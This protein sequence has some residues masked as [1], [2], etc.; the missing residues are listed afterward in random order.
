M[1]KDKTHPQQ[2]TPTSTQKSSD[3]K[4]SS[5]SAEPLKLIKTA[6]NAG[7]TRTS[8]ACDRCRIKKIKCDGKIPSC[9]NCLNIGYNCQTSDKLTRRAFPRGYTENL[10]KNLITI[11]N[12][13]AKLITELEIVKQ[14]LSA[15][16]ASNG[17]DSSG[18][19]TTTATTT[20][21]ASVSGTT[22]TPS[23][24]IP[25]NSENAPNERESTSPATSDHAPVMMDR[26]SD[27][28]FRFDN[29]IEKD[30]Y[31]GIDCISVLFN[32]MLES[33]GLNPIEELKYP[34][35]QCPSLNDFITTKFLNK[36]PS[37]TNLDLLISNHFEHLNTIPILDEDLFFKIYK[38]MFNSIDNKTENLVNLLQKPVSG[39]EEKDESDCLVFI[40]TLVLI[41]QLNCSIFNIHEIHKLV[42]SINLTVNMTIP[43]FQVL[44][45]SLHLFQNK[46][47]YKNTVINLANVAHAAVLS[48]GL[49][50]NYN[51][52]RQ[53]SNEYTNTK[54]EKFRLY[55]VRL[56]L[57]WSFY[58]LS[59][60]SQVLF[61]LPHVSFFEKFQVPK[62]N[63]IVN[64]NQNLR[65]T[66]KLIE[67]LSKFEDVNLLS[68]GDNPQVLK[69]FDNY[70]LQW[71]QGCG[72]N[73]LFNTLSSDD[74]D[75]HRHKKVKKSKT[76][77]SQDEVV[78]IQLNLFY[79]MFR[80]SIHLQTANEPGNP[81]SSHSSYVVSLLSREYLAYIIILDRKRE[82]NNLNNFEFHLVPINF[83]KL[84]LISM[85]SIV[86]VSRDPLNSTTKV[87]FKDSNKLMLQTLKVIRRRYPENFV[88]FK[89]IVQF[90][91]NEF[92]LQDFE[93]DSNRMSVSQQNVTVDSFSTPMHTNSLFTDSN[94]DA[95]QQRHQSSSSDNSSVSNVSSIFSNH[96]TSQNFNGD[97][98]TAAIRATANIAPGAESDTSSMDELPEL[99]SKLEMLFNWGSTDTK[100]QQDFKPL[101]D[102]KVSGAMMAYDLN[103]I[104]DK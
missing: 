86:Q 63:T 31:V 57:Y 45:L 32:R 24:V 61:G 59:T 64:A 36:F 65:N 74:I 50:L 22:T 52:L 95:F 3:S 43:K 30:N 27:N 44:L 82:L 96:Y 93:L 69:E 10:E 21:D 72:L 46:N 80:I 9:T 73:N 16:T 87:A 56:K 83:L 54:E 29:F 17:Y 53:L 42:T 19:A 77:L 20:T 89:E 12:E 28:F 60:M 7:L 99:D 91:K 103:Y 13:N 88:L 33:L 85:L 58:I 75:E 67:L 101:D 5:S 38:Q 84:V 104:I 35:I 90:I 48:L 23:L 68:I 40:A 92:M 2:Q 51:N 37:K 39:D 71:R 34:A 79:L 81:I 49:H 4:S 47:C 94:F 8:Q 18:A 1:T 76:S 26:L 66:I 6:G 100:V 55:T 102:S 25:A 78:K 14:Q 70:L 11:Q 98:S 97:A 41:I 62:L 15:V